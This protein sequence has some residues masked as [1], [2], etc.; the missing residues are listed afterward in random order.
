MLGNTVASAI[1]RS[2]LC[3]LSGLVLSLWECINLLEDLITHQSMYIYKY[4]IFSVKLKKTDC[5]YLN[6]AYLV[7]CVCYSKSTPSAPVVAVILVC[8]S[9]KVHVSWSNLVTCACFL[10]PCARAKTLHCW[11]GGGALGQSLAIYSWPSTSIWAIMV[12]AWI[13]SLV[14]LVTISSASLC[15]ACTL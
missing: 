2:L 8:L 4:N 3:I 7:V 12:S 14:S 5:T 6:E 11:Y 1:Q 15:A 9:S 13:A 10:A